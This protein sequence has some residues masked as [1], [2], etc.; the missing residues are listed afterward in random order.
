[1]KW[2][3]EMGDGGVI[4]GDG[5]W[6]LTGENFSCC[7]A[8]LLAL[9]GRDTGGSGGFDQSFEFFLVE[10]RDVFVMDFMEWN[11]FV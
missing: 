7:C 1:M 4:D 6:F 3:E 8:E 11:V 2:S 9:S 10:R 5:L